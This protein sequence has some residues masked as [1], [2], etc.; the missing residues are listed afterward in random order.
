MTQSPVRFI[1]EVARKAGHTVAINHFAED[2]PSVPF[3]EKATPPLGSFVEVRVTDGVAHPVG[4]V[5]AGPKSALSTLVRIAASH[6]MNPIFDPNVEAEIEAIVAGSDTGRPPGTDDPSL[7]DLLDRPFVTIDNEDSRD[8][9]QALYIERTADSGYR[10]Y[11]ALADA[12]YYV[13]PGT[14]LFRDALRRGASFYFPGWMV[15]MLPRAL[16][17]GLVSLNEGVV[18][19]ALVFEMSLDSTATEVTTEVYRARIE[20]RAKLT[21]DGVQ[22]LLDQGDAHRLGGREFTPSLRLLKEV[23]LL[24]IA[25]ASSRDVVSHRRRAVEVGLA[26]RRSF[27]IYSGLRND[28]ERY[29]EQISLL[30][31]VEGAK[32]I[33][34]AHHAE[35]MQAIY[36]VHPPPPGPRVQAFK[37]MVGGLTGAHELDG[38]DRWTWDRDGGQS[39]ANFLENLDW[40]TQ[41][42]LAR[43]IQRQ[44]IVMNV[45]STFSSEASNHH[46]VGADV[47]A[48][49]SSPMRE[50]VGVFLHKE[51][52]EA[53]GIERHDPEGDEAI[54]ALVIDAANRS[55]ALQRRITSLANRLAIDQLFEQDAQLPMEKRPRRRGTVMGLTGGKIHVS[56]DDPPIDVKLYRRELER[57][58]KSKIR[59]RS[60]GIE[61]RAEDGAKIARV[62]EAID[63]FVL[64]QDAKRDRWILVPDRLPA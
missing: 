42:R 22:E 23:G 1:G 32:L 24:R 11:Y 17:E 36:R 19:R 62:G 44:A 45:R 64:R 35:T 60:S 16:S 56:L 31:N 14:A 40:E 34:A 53:L 27:V 51:L 55:K 9:D 5:F 41:P 37:K 58:A 21:Y 7:L 57:Q 46:G 52:A 50:I 18:R 3:H 54:R 25:E 8:L 49:F 2:A 33:H 48:R 30:C 63:L 43:A 38:D 61:M 28:V 59:L 12:A 10:V 13:R 29:N 47:Y 39:L 4:E 6:A 15:P 26:D 20:S